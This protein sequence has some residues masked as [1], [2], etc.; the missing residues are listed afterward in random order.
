ML[1]DAVL[2]IQALQTGAHEFLAC[3][4]GGGSSHSGY[5]FVVFWKFSSCSWTSARPTASVMA[6]ASFFRKKV[7][8]IVGGAGSGAYSSNTEE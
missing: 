5:G 7:S 2:A 1:H 4:N 8:A 6:L 3:D